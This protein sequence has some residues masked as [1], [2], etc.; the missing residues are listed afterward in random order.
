M[1]MSPGP[2]GPRTGD[3]YKLIPILQIVHSLDRSHTGVVTQVQTQLREGSCEIFVISKANAD[4]EIKD[5]RRRAPE[6]ERVY[7]RKLIVSPR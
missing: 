1:T 2:L 4:L 7:G 3:H 5:A 6:F